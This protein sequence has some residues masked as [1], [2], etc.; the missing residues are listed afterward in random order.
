MGNELKKKQHNLFDLKHL[1]KSK[2]VWLTVLWLI[3]MV[4][5]IVAMTDVFSASIFQRKYLTIWIIM[6]ASTI[7]II[8]IHLEYFKNK[9]N[10]S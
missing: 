9:S 3:A 2:I 1:N 5:C 8:Q 6:V 4:S 10:F 7:K